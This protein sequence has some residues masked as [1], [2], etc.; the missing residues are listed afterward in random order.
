MTVRLQKFS[1][2]RETT[3][4]RKLQVAVSHKPLVRSRFQEEL[5]LFCF[6]YLTLQAF[7]V[8]S[9]VRVICKRGIGILPDDG[10]KG[11]PFGNFYFF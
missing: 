7:L 8:F 6:F 5:F 1:Y 3:E 11:C 9:V 10:C 2:L 4:W